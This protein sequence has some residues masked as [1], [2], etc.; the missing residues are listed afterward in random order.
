ME[1]LNRRLIYARDAMG[2]DK[3]IKVNVELQE[4]IRRDKRREE[5]RAIEKILVLRAR[6]N[7]RKR[8]RDESK[9]FVLHSPTVFKGVG[10]CFFHD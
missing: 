5:Q 8:Q 4:K 2:R 10:H 7:E 6:D 1:D 3:M 9:R